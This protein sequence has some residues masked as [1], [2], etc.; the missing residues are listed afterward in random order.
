MA[1]GRAIFETEADAERARINGWVSEG[2]SGNVI[3][4]TFY[5]G[6]PHVED[7][8]RWH[9]EDEAKRRA[10]MQLEIELARAKKAPACT[11][12]TTHTP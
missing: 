3:A 6:E 9:E 4:L 1:P 7:F 11:F 10:I 12:V 8:K 2:S 5:E